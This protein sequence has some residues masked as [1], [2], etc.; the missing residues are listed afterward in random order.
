MTQTLDP[1]RLKHLRG[2]LS[3]DELAKK[4]GV[5]KQTIYR[6]EKERRPI[7]P[8]TLARLSRALAVEPD[9]LTGEKPLPNT[10]QG[11]SEPADDSTY[12]VKAPLDASTRN[13][14]SLA[15]L[16]YGIPVSLIVEL[17]PLLFVLLAEG[18]L[19]ERRERIEELESAFDSISSLNPKFPHLPPHITYAGDADETI[20]AEK[21]SIAARDIYADKIPREIY[22]DNEIEYELNNPFARYLRELS[23]ST[24][25]VANPD[26]LSSG[27]FAGYE[28]CREQAI[29][30]AGGDE[31]LAGEILN[32]SVVI[33]KIPREL[34]KKTADRVEWIRS[35]LAPILKAREESRK[36]SKEDLPQHLFAERTIL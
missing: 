34:L 35:A 25:G 8:G 20:Q 18:S 7:R 31:S 5:N 16:R 36:S 33:H 13:A 23:A 11:S 14:F 6:L 29:T 24:G 19:K 22:W 15:A 10:G 26:E 3:Q 4:A 30:L 28:V 12:Y 17:A 32:G 9:V 21:A 1:N 2:R 27:R